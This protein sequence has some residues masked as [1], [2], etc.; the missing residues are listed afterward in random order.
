MA[1][2][3]T[4]TPDNKV[5]LTRT[6]MISHTQELLFPVH[7]L[8]VHVWLKL[9]ESTSRKCGADVFLLTS[10]LCNVPGIEYHRGYLK[11]RIVK[12]ALGKARP[13]AIDFSHSNGIVDGYMV[14]SYS[15][16]FAVS[17]VQLHYRF[18][19]PCTS[20]LGCEPER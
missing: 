9:G 14:G 12:R 7:E 5:D 3:R 20:A 19:T 8:Q 17:L 16:K 4:L 10:M 18:R 6:N 11:E 15:D 13:V 2:F 1:N